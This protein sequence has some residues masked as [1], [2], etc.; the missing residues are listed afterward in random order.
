MPF[1]GL[2]NKYRG[3]LRLMFYNTRELSFNNFE[4]TLGFKDANHTGALLTFTEEENPFT[5]SYDRA[6]EEFM[7]TTA[8]SINGWI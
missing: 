8:N 6:K 7:L 2:Y 4:V 1:L 3:K 5:H